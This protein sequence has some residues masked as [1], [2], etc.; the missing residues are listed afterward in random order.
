MG[1]EDDCLTVQAIGRQRCRILQPIKKSDLFYVDSYTVITKN[2]SVLTLDDLT[3][4]S[5]T[6]SPN[7]SFN[8]LSKKIVIKIL[9]FLNKKFFLNCR[10]RVILLLYFIMILL[11]LHNY[12]RF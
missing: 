4:P 9:I 2:I 8:K 6:Y 1:T 12:R 7:T 5:I 10:K 11:L 3:L